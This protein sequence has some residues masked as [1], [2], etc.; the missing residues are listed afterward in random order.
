NYWNEFRG[1]DVVQVTGHN[2]SCDPADEPDMSAC[3]ASSVYATTE[4]RFHQGMDNDPDWAGNPRDFKVKFVNP[5]TGATTRSVDDSEWLAGQQIQS[6]T[7]I[8]NDPDTVLVN[9]VV[10]N[11]NN[12][13]ATSDGF[14]VYATVPNKAR[15]VAVK[16]TSTTTY[17][18]GTKT[19]RT[20]PTFTNNS[21]D[22][23]VRLTALVE[24][25]DSAV[26]G[27]ERRVEYT[28]NPQVTNWI[29][30]PVSS[31]VLKAGPD[32]TSTKL[33]RTDYVYN[34]DRD[35]IETRAC[36]GL[37]TCGSYQETSFQVDAQGRVTQVTDA[38]GRDVITV[39]DAGY[40]FVDVVTDQ[41]LFAGGTNMVTDTVSYDPGFGVALETVDPA[42]QTTVA[43]YDEYGR[44]VKGWLPGQSGNPSVVYTY[45]DTNGQD[46]VKVKTATLL[47]GST[48]VDRFD[49]YDGFGR[50]IQ[51]QAASPDGSGRVVTA[52]FYNRKGVIERETAGFDDA[53]TLG[54]WMDPVWAG[55]SPTM[56][57]HTLYTSD[58]FGRLTLSE[59]IS[60]NLDGEVISDTSSSYDRWSTT[61]T[62]GPGFA[63]EGIFRKTKSTT[64]AYGN[65]AQVVDYNNTSSY[66][67]TSYSYDARDLLTQV[68]NSL[69]GVTS[70]VVYDALGRKTSIDDADMGDWSYTYDAVGNLQTQTDARNQTLWFKYDEFNRMTEKHRGNSTGFLVAEWVWDNNR[71][72]AL[73]KSISYEDLTVPEDPAWEWRVTVDPT[74]YDPMGRVTSQTIKIKQSG[75]PEDVYSTSWGYNAAGLVT[76]LDLPSV[77]GIQED[78]DYTYNTTTAL[79]TKLTTSVSGGGNVVAAASYNPQ[80][81]PTELVYGSG[82]AN[83]FHESWIYNPDNLAL[84]E[85]RLG[86]NGTGTFNLFRLV[87]DFDP[88]Y[89][90]EWIRD[91]RN[92]LQYQCYRYDHLYRLTD[93]YTD[94][95]TGSCD[96]GTSTT[97]GV[98]YYDLG[99]NYDKT[100]D[101]TSVTG[102]VDGAGAAMSYSYTNA[103]HLHAVTADGTATYSYDATGN[104]TIRNVSGQQDLLKWDESNRLYQVNPNGSAKSQ[105][106]YDADGTRVVRIGDVNDPATVTYTLGS[107]LEVTDP[108]G[109]TEQVTVHYQF[110]AQTVGFRHTD[111]GGTQRFY[112]ASDHLGSNGVQVRQSDK[113]ATSQYHLPYGDYRGGSTNGLE[114]EH[115]YTGQ[116]DDTP[117]TSSGLMFYNAR[118]YRPTL[119]RFIS[120]DS[121]VPDPADSQAHNRYA[122]V[123]NNPVNGSDPSGR[124]LILADPC[125][126]C[127]NVLGSVN[128]ERTATG[129]V[130]YWGTDNEGVDWSWGES[131]AEMQARGIMVNLRAS[132]SV[133][134]V[135]GTVFRE[136]V[137]DWECS[138]WVGCGIE[139]AGILPWGKLA[140]GADVLK[141]VF[142][143]GDEAADTARLGDDLIEGAGDLVRKGPLP[144]E[145]A[146]NLP[147]QLALDA[148]RAG[149]GEIIIENLGD[150][151]RLNDN[152]GPGEWVK[153]QYVLRG[154][155][156][157]VTVHWF[158]NLTTNMDV[159][160]KFTSRYSPP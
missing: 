40:G 150:V 125:Y 74:G 45:F 136:T 98:G 62:D 52:R 119:R 118:Y 92:Q 94:S 8:N 90:V 30:F 73:D 59:L 147:E 38:M 25:G 5:K 123:A 63:S 49:F 80:G 133:G 121:I 85:H 66:L 152:Y 148:A 156:D 65:L 16:D 145:V 57:L 105:Y 82:G 126:L 109:T 140:K 55:T 99:Y 15:F 138:G 33:A 56:P 18:S 114:T 2:G 47:S 95:G 96:D 24:H 39:Y 131:N 70:Q 89:Q 77:G 26:T 93:A 144:D 35:L 130:R 128:A 6:F 48:Y 36:S 14:H 153:M 111:T 27:D 115:T 107:G 64:D 46:P 155:D 86:S 108:G 34:G 67:T 134:G 135:L 79:P 146:N 3:S 23:F 159:E 17:G 75:Q 132:R 13:S 101:I 122:Y 113:A 127:S 120:P 88:V 1:H 158:R 10:S 106:V 84:Q 22:R 104:M 129:G 50:H 81:Q 61:V 137:F 112:L 32:S 116:I 41:G 76:D 12:S 87:Y 160:F 69:D 149:N 51:A 9:T 83:V 44:L 43:G 72:G 143:W 117:A 110:G 103:A 124:Y 154:V 54:T 142:R 53:G 31:Q 21:T 151:G 42:G 100:G 102:T 11:T 29:M 71:V 20:Q 97:T 4:Y 78:L 60:K 28:Y 157:N 37:A 141:G 91:N 7:F 139:W 58:K 19:T 68:S